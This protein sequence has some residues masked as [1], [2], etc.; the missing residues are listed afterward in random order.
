M[1]K[2]ECFC[3]SSCLEK[4]VYLEESDGISRS[5]LQSENNAGNIDVSS[6]LIHWWYLPIDDLLVDLPDKIS[7]IS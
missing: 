3:V 5:V 4:R 7:V 6:K 1:L 2:S